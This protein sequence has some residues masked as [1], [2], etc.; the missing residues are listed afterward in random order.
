MND[1]NK[2]TVEEW[3]GSKE[4]A[5]EICDEA[6]SLEEAK[7]AVVYQTWTDK[8]GYFKSR[9]VFVVTCKNHFND[10]NEKE[11]D[12]RELANLTGDYL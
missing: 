1:T 12:Y 4:P 8:L 9:R 5:C 11:I 3:L 2:P 7:L 10:L 6:L